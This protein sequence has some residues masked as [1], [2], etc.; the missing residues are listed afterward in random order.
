MLEKYNYSVKTFLM[1]QA[2]VVVLDG[3][4][5]NRQYS[6]LN[7]VKNVKTALS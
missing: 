1:E 7:P 5:E 6:I 4:G 2:D 3:D